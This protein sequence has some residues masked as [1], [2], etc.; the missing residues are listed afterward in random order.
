MTRRRTASQFRRTSAEEQI[1]ASIIELV[2]IKAP[3][4]LCFCIP[5]GLPSTARSVHRYKTRLGLY[6]GAADIALVHQGRVYFIEVK[7]ADGMQRKEQR[8]F[9][10][11]A[12]AAG[13]PYAI[14]RDI[15]EADDTIAS[16]GIWER[17]REAA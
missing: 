13:A 12:E 1:H 17:R 3:H 5:N 6:P 15:W 2:G 7:T 4:L 8:A 9:Q 14:V 16:W 11:H 10:L